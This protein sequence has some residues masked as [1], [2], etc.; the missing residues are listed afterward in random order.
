[1][2]RSLHKI[3]AG[4]VTCRAGDAGHWESVGVKTTR[5]VETTAT[6]TYFR[7]VE[8]KDTMPANPFQK[9]RYQVQKVAKVDRP[10]AGSISGIPTG[11]LQT[12]QRQ[13]KEVRKRSQYKQD[14]QES[15]VFSRM[16]AI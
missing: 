8:A 13:T 1:M 14:D 11:V 2:M 16:K 15:S 12:K 3:A 5:A 6:H 9:V 7:P 10:A 4:N